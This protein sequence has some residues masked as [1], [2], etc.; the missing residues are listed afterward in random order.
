MMM[1]IWKTGVL[2]EDGE[3]S[4]GQTEC[5]VLTGYADGDIC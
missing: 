4:F 3:L 5:K 1:E 2:T